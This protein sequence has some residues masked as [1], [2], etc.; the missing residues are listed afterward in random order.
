[1]VDKITGLV[2]TRGLNRSPQPGLP[3]PSSVIKDLSTRLGNLEYGHGQ[4]VKKVIQVSNAKVAAGVSIREIG[5]RVF[6]MEGQ[7]QS[8]MKDVDSSQ[9]P[10]VDHTFST[11]EMSFSIPPNLINKNKNVD[12]GENVQELEIDS[13]SDRDEYDIEDEMDD[14]DDNYDPTNILVD[15]DNIID[16]HDVDLVV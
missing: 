12:E 7:M 8:A 13:E 14:I 4:L 10:E 2:S 16:E 1:M 6:S 9:L 5:P 3:I 15:E 11:L